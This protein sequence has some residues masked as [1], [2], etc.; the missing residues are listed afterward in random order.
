MPASSEPRSQPLATRGPVARPGAGAAQ[1]S[2]RRWAAL[3]ICSDLAVALIAGIAGVA[4]RFGGEPTTTLDGLSYWI[5]PPLVAPLWCLVLAGI[6][7]YDR[8]SI[9]SGVEELR[10]IGNAVIWMLAALALVSYVLRADISR[11]IV[12]LTLVLLCVLTISSHRAVRALLRRRLRRPG[13]YLHRL[14]TVGLSADASRLIEHLGEA[15]TG[16]E[17]A[18][19]LAPEPPARPGAGCVLPEHEIVAAARRAGADTI[20]VCSIESLAAGELRRL[21]WTI[22][23]TGLRLLAVPALTDVAGPRIVPWPLA[24]LPLLEIETPEFTGLR[25]ITKDVLDRVLATVLVLL[26]IPILVMASL[27]IWIGDRGPVL[28]RQ[29]RVGKDGRDFSIWKLRTMRVGADQEHA[30]LAA[31]ARHEG[32]L[33]K[34]RR[35]PRVT[36]VGRVLRRLSI[37]ELPQLINVVNGSMSLVGPRPPLPTE[38]A[39]YE[40]DA[41]RRLLVRPGITGLWQVS[42]RSDLSWAEAL[43]LD[44]YYV[45]NWSVAL[46]LLILA[47][48]VG[49]VLRSR[50]AY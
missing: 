38:V 43:R 36:P 45:E 39:S 12:G 22:E 7:A 24:G 29:T 2:T 44:L 40:D 46:D 21:S 35:D 30:D 17:V 41:R 8:R 16:F 18:A 6:G 13:A 1:I 26:S 33:F 11:G 32:I 31:A 5:L 48:T 4:L 50:G 28:Y 49:A 27:A 14:V 42:G 34:L 10:K 47:R 25:R 9:N 37:D 19:T 15:P 3:L 20:A 23:G